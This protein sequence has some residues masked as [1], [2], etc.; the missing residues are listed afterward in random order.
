MKNIIELVR[1]N[2]RTIVPYSSARSEHQLLE[3][4]LLDANEN[5]F[6]ELNRYPDPLQTE[7]KAA[8]A[9]QFLVDQR[10]VFIG[11]G[12]DEI[13]DL[14]FRLFCIPGKDAA[15]TVS[16]TYGMY[17]VTAALNDVRLIE[18]E[19]D[20]E[21]DLD[22][23]ALLQQ[24]EL[25]SPKLLLLCSPNNPTGNTLDSQRMEALVSTFQ[26]IVV[27]DEAYIDFANNTTISNWI[28][29]YPNL[30]VLRTMS[31]AWGLAGARI[32]MAF[33]TQ[34]LIG[35]LTTIKPPY[36]V[37]ALNQE[38]ALK[39]LSRP[40]DFKDQINVLLAERT[41]LQ[42]ALEHIECIRHV[43]P[44]QANFLLTE[45]ND[46]LSV[47]TYLKKAGMLVRNRTSE[48]ENCLRITVGT[49]QENDQLIQLLQNY[50]A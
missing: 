30:I 28:Q 31:K 8:I 34:E 49:P 32:G 38:A 35:L 47:Y 23:P 12:S 9:K 10:E 21:F 2:I 22:L 42:N 1:P 19:L 48:I 4:V 26:G 15:L 25:V 43:Y 29:N 18:V 17:K 3:G 46:A 7:L 11:N 13:I 39:A 37:S 44:S 45:V 16:P 6:G 5:P 50:Q 41:R 40:N 27:V 36:N 24:I 20:T 33:A 14:I